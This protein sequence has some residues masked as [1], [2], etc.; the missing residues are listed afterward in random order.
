MVPAPVRLSITTG[1][2]STAVSFWPTMRASTSVEP[3]AAYGTTMRKGRVGKFC[4]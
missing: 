2:P 4:A 1:W 3:P